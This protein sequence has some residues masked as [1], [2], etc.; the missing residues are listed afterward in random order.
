M[1]TRALAFVAGLL[2]QRMLSVRDDFE[3]RLEAL[4]DEA[5][6]RAERREASQ[7]R[8]AD[9]IG[10]SERA[11]LCG[12]CQ[13]EPASFARFKAG[14]SLHCDWCMS[15]CRLATGEH[16]P[17]DVEGRERSTNN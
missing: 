12:C 17:R 2:V 6:A 15:N 1:I 4:E 16:K 7:E 10:K 5:E 9:E 11:P 3:D 8:S 14:G 13:E